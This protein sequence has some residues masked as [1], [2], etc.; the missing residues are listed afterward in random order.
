MKK[1]L[2][3]FCLVPIL[4]SAEVEDDFLSLLDEVTEIAT[5]TKLNVDYVPGVVTVIKGKELQ[6]L[7][8]ST[9]SEWSSFNMIS[10]IDRIRGIRGINEAYGLAKIKFLINSKPINFAITGAPTFPPI[11]TSLIDRIEVIR[12]PG[13]AIYGENAYSGVINI[14]TKKDIK[15]I[16][17]DYIVHNQKN[18]GKALSVNNFYEN[19]EL[20]LNINFS[21]Y[22]DDGINLNTQ[23]DTTYY[24]DGSSVN[25]TLED[26]KVNS[27]LNVD[28]NYNDYL[29]SLIYFNRKGG[30]IYGQSGFLPPDDDI[31]NYQEEVLNI[32]AKKS[33]EF[34]GVESVPKVGYIVF[35]QNNENLHY[36]SKGYMPS[37]YGNGLEITAD[38]K[39]E[40]YYAGVD[41]FYTIDNHKLLLGLEYI[42]TKL[43]DVDYKSNFDP[44]TNEEYKTKVSFTGEKNALKE[45]VSRK[46]SAIYLQDEWNPTQPLTITLGVRWDSYD[47]VGDS[48]N[49]RVAGV[50]RLSDNHIFKMQY[51]KAFKPPTFFDLYFQNNPVYSGN[52][53]ME[54]EDIDTYELGYIYNSTDE[55]FRVMFFYSNLKNMIGYDFETSE[56]RNLSEAKTKGFEVEYIKQINEWTKLTSNFSISDTKD[57]MT[58]KPFPNVAK[59]LANVILNLTPFDDISFNLWYQ[60]IGKKPREAGDIRD[61]FKK[62]HIVN[63]SLK[64][65]NLSDN[66]SMMIGVNDIFN[67]G[68]IYPSNIGTYPN[69]KTWE[70]R[71]FWVNL[72]YRF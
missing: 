17:F 37:I 29:L 46:S 69:D 33:F 14:V 40:R 24:I 44:L 53:D 8:V 43:K 56:L 59:T 12:G 7:G 41:N 25:R 23:K 22:I 20:I 42:Y 72:N 50:Y 66:L 60:Y 4:L 28:L 51:A 71:N 16:S 21:R 70:K 38:F 65:D 62:Q 10:G 67:K 2:M 6:A 49:P 34:N 58:N 48:I 35:N 47:D 32:E 9:L 68:L 61:V 1:I 54:P 31:L 15:D 45:N 52:P 55:V 30:E 19:E 13:S 63:T 64:I 11:S 5:K 26:D 39:E 57:E 36:V 18:S 27:F 3:S